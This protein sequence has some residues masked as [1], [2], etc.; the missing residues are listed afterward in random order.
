MNEIA[1]FNTLLHL[2]LLYFLQGMC[3]LEVWVK[4]FTYHFKLYH[5]YQVPVGIYY[6]CIRTYELINTKKY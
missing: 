6:M 3:V 5:A 1:L 2:F 4:V